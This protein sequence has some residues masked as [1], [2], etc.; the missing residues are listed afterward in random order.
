MKKQVVTRKYVFTKVDSTALGL[1]AF[2]L[3]FILGIAWIQK[4]EYVDSDFHY[5]EGR[6]V[7][8][9][10]WE[11]N[12]HHTLIMK[13][14]GI[15]IHVVPRKQMQGECSNN[16]VAVSDYGKLVDKSSINGCEVEHHDGSI[17]IWVLK[18]DTSPTLLHELCHADGSY[19]QKEC[20]DMF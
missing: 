16:G 20:A 5:S 17:D 4:H 10:R 19:T 11:G 9:F 8:D 7:F 2:L 13:N 3:S 15:T 12:Y 1:A 6:T 14:K 18:E